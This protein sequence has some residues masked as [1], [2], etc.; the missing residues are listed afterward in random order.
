[1][2][3]DEDLK[4][5]NVPLMFLV[6]ELEKLYS[7]RKAIE[8]LK[9]L[10]PDVIAKSIPKASHCITRSQANLV[11]ENIIDFIGD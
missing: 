3:S 5:I 1:M 2:L 4:K 8:R 6:G 9:G 7:P 10:L 11:N